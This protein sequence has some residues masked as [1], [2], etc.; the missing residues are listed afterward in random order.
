MARGTGL[1]D[2]SNSVFILALSALQASK[3]FSSFWVRTPRSISVMVSSGTIF[4]PGVGSVRIEGTVK[5]LV[6]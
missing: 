2:F 1:E 4:G 5:L 3:A 6:S